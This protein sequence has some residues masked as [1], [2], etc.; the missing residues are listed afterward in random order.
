MELTERVH[1]YTASD[2]S[3]G[4]QIPRINVLIGKRSSWFTF[5]DVNDVIE[6]YETQKK[7]VEQIL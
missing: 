7:N 4:W 6:L 5:T 2:L 3:L 1:F